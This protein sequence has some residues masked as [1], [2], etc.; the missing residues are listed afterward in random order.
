MLSL[1]VVGVALSLP[2][3]DPTPPRHLIIARPTSLPV[4]FADVP[5]NC[6]FHTA[7][8]KL[9][10]LLLIFPVCTFESASIP[11]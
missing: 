11:L 3:N 4:N 1:L 7:Y 10:V 2:S 9:W 8:K 6:L 5:R